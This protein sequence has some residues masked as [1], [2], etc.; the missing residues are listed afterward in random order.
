MICCST[1]RVGPFTVLLECRPGK[2]VDGVVDA[3]DHLQFVGH[4]QWPNN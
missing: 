2:S 4:R 1:F 3:G